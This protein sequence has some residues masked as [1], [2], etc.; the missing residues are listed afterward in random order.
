MLLFWNDI[1]FPMFLSCQGRKLLRSYQCP[2]C[3]HRFLLILTPHMTCPA[4]FG[5]VHSQKPSLSLHRWATHT[6]EYNVSFLFFLFSQ[7]NK[8]K[9]LIHQRQFLDTW[10]ISLTKEQLR[11]QKQKHIVF[12]LCTLNV[13][14]LCRNE[15]F[16]QTVLI[17]ENGE[18]ASEN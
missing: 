14:S 9:W 6:S 15:L 3:L 2:K 10:E 1:F 18:L 17:C 4:L 13:N 8:D 7:G 16:K 12:A 5:S 11:K